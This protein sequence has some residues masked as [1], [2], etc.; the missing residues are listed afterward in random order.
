VKW[1]LGRRAGTPVKEGFVGVRKGFYFLAGRQ[2]LILKRLMR[3]RIS[4]RKLLIARKAASVFA[5]MPTVKMVG[6]TGALAMENAD[7][8]SDIDFLVITRKG[9]LWLTRLF[10]L[11]TLRLVGLPTRRFDDKKQ[12]DKLCLN[13]WLDESRLVWPKKDRNLYTAHE[14]AQIVPLVN[15]EQTYER[16]IYL[17]RWVRL[18]WPNAVRQTKKPAHRNTQTTILLSPFEALAYGLQYR[19]MKPKITRERVGLTKAIF[20]PINWW[21]I[22]KVKVDGI[23]QT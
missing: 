9:T 7:T 13:M 19:Y 8:E 4:Q 1:E 11:L 10:T 15:K 18:Y 22:L 5:V 3:H 6:I 12:A 14:I 16:F 23:L 2:G 17:N 20:H 21:E